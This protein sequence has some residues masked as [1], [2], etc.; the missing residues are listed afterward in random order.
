MSRSKDVQAGL[1]PFALQLWENLSSSLR[2]NKDWL[3]CFWRLRDIDYEEAF[4]Q[5]FYRFLLKALFGK[6]HIKLCRYAQFSVCFCALSPLIRPTLNQFLNFKLFMHCVTIAWNFHKI[7][8]FEYYGMK[9]FISIPLL[10][11]E[12]LSNQLLARK[13]SIIYC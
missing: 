5:Y 8:V 12:M 1:E 6:M 10:L 2:V 3:F 11:K 9:L 13:L 4:T 7:W